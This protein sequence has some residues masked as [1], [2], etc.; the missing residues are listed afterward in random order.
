M[1][2]DLK[3]EGRIEEWRRTV[4]DQKEW[5]AVIPELVDLNKEAEQ[6]EKER[7]DDKKRREEETMSGLAWPD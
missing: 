4:I 5:R 7:K 3:K 1:S 6:L 2:K